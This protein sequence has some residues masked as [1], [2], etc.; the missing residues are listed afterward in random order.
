MH[1]LP[2]RALKPSAIRDPN[3]PPG[4][5]KEIPASTRP[6]TA[7]AQGIMQ[8]DDLCREPEMRKARSWWVEPFRLE[9]AVNFMDVA[10]AKGTAE[11]SR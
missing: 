11:S 5:V 6:T 9:I 1:R 7:D 2:E 10:S 4:N 3:S 8:L